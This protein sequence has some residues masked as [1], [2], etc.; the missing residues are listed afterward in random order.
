VAP[1][2][3]NPAATPG[4]P[5][6]GGGIWTPL[7]DWSTRRLVLVA[8][9]GLAAAVL[10]VVTLMIASGPVEVFTGDFA[11][12]SVLVVGPLEVYAYA[13][14]TPHDNVPV[15]RGSLIDGVTEIGNALPRLPAWSGPGFVW[16]PSVRRAAP[17]RY[18]LYYA[19]V[20]RSN[21]L[22]C[23]SVATGTRPQGPFVDDSTAPL[24]CQTA[25]GGSIDPTTVTDG[26]TTYLLWKSD[27][28]C[29]AKPSAIWAAPLS[30]D[31]LRIA[32]PPVSVLTATQPW[33]RGVV[34]GPSMITDGDRF[35]LF[36]SGGEWNTAGYAMGYAVCT[37]P[38]GPCRLPSPDPF[39]TSR[40]GQ[41]GPGGGEA[42][43]G[44]GGAPWI[45]YSAWTGGRVGYAAG[46]SRS[47]FVSPLD[48]S[49]TVPRLGSGF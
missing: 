28:S 37:T 33:E 4:A 26:G 38:L 11:D 3:P 22:E 25:L 45:V 13:T 31:G 19:T 40:G 12:P 47:L 34:E 8:A 9:L 17:D 20:A 6:V 21:G 15:L 10:L 27:G 24:E 5:P 43:L 42:F 49:G 30:A 29:C 46:G 36:F 48:L 14:N 16:A 41:E 2:A 44:P 32:A 18:L 1:A 7:A 23:L 35:D 39:L